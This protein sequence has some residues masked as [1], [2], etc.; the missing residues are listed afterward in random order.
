[1]NTFPE[2]AVA[3]SILIDHRAL[4]VIRTLV[5]ADDFKLSACAAIFRAACRLSDNGLVVDPVSIQANAAAYGDELPTEFLTQLMEITP[6]AANA[7]QYAE[8]VH[9]HGLRRRIQNMATEI[10]ELSK[11]A[12][13]PTP[14]LLTTAAESLHRIEAGITSALVPSQDAAAD[15]LNYREHTAETG[16]A[17]I[18]TGYTKL[19][20]LMG[21]GM[22]KE[23]LYILAARPGVG[24]T[25]LGM[26]IADY[27]SK[28]RPVLFVSLEMS[29]EQLTARRVADRTAI[30]I[31]KV[32]LDCAMNTEEQEKLCTALAEIA[33][34]KMTM[35]RRAGA[36][37]ADISML[38][39]SIP[40]LALIVID[41]LGLIQCEDMRADAYERTT[42]NSNALKRLA[43]SL[44]V[45]VLC[46]AQLN[47]ASEQRSDKR[48]LM[49]DLRD[50]GAIEQD[51]D[52]VL[53]LHRPAYYLK[54]GDPHKPK[55]WEPERLELDLVKNRHG[56]TGNINLDFYPI[57]GRIRE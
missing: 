28:T 16:G 51:A 40:D 17:V 8:I 43:R 9:D 13:I 56:S 48:P 45:P 30:S 54:P 15:F 36:T 5:Q 22:V 12:E 2:Q 46:L 3:G 57:N 7:M 34:T 14:K 21:G 23:G 1:M 38:A 18:P 39:H 27:V 25:T 53:L 44:G 47:R 49:A 33:E 35:N 29:I 32:M 52:A 26:K 42:K 6:T 11:D 10:T 4:P 50:S 31:G 19:D 24:K 20:K 55:A 41:Y 37:V